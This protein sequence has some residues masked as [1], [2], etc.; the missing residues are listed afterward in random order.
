MELIGVLR[1][2]EV[3]LCEAGRLLL[4]LAQLAPF[5]K[6]AHGPAFCMNEGYASLFK[7]SGDAGE[8]VGNGHVRATFEI[9]NGLP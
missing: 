3:W 2:N 6:N 5:E 4:D 9:S 1:G 7:R 8:I